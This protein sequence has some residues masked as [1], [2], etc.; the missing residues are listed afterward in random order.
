MGDRE[1]PLA[2]DTAVPSRPRVWSSK[3]FEGQR[4]I[5]IVHAG[6]E[7]LLRITKSDKLILTK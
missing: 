3:L 2:S 1:R 4:E 6:S 7:H 5:V